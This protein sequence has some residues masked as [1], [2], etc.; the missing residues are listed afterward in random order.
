M[1]CILETV[2][3]L[4]VFLPLIGK[5]YKLFTQDGFLLHRFYGILSQMVAMLFFTLF[6]IPLSAS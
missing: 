2:Y 6:F 5:S 3:Y 1:T 4:R